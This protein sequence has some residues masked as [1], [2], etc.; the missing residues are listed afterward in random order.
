MERINGIPVPYK[1]NRV[2][3][4]SCSSPCAMEYTDGPDKG[5]VQCMSNDITNHCKYFGDKKGNIKERRKSL[6]TVPK[7][8]AEKLDSL[9][10]KRSMK[11]FR[12]RIRNFHKG[13]EDEGIFPEERKMRYRH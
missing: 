12:N 6:R 11:E 4:P 3:C 1:F 7:W 13:L 9:K 10:R 5:L 2:R 8:F